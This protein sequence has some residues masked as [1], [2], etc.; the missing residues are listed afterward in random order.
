MTISIEER[1]LLDSFR[2]ALPL[3][4]TLVVFD[5]RVNE[6]QVVADSAT[7]VR[8]CLDPSAIFIEGSRGGFPNQV[9]TVFGF[10][11]R[12]RHTVAASLEGSV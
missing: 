12:A 11:G 3:S 7:T 1:A 5:H 2:G 8:L 10:E 9:S 4:V 6:W